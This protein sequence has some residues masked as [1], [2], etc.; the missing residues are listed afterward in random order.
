MRKYEDFPKAGFWPSRRTVQNAPENDRIL[1]GAQPHIVAPNV[2]A[3]PC[4]SFGGERE[5]RR[6]GRPLSKKEKAVW[7]SNLPYGPEK[8][9]CLL[10]GVLLKPLPLLIC[11]VV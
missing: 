3:G 6:T 2:Y 4:R 9:H 1:P 5:S 7:H 8:Y 11:P 10:M